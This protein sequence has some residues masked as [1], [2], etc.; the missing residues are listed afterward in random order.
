MHRN[1]TYTSEITVRLADHTDSRALIDLAALDSA[2]VPAGAL[3]IAES[4]GELVAAVPIDGGRAIADPFR[5]T[6]LIVQMLE[7]RAAQIR[8]RSQQ[9]HGIA[10]RVRSLAGLQPA[11]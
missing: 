2:Q 5:G 1:T 3:V 8:S 4:D 11:A 10:R 7:L 9:P 6:Q